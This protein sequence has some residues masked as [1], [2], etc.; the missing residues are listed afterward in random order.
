VQ[1]GD[2]GLCLKVR[3]GKGD[4]KRVSANL[5]T[6]EEKTGQNE[7]SYCPYLRMSGDIKIRIS[8]LSSNFKFV[9]SFINL[10]IILHIFQVLFKSYI[11]VECDWSM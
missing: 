6:G 4:G 1:I 11:Q 9:C 3:A 7:M 5:R 10:H 2:K 8:L